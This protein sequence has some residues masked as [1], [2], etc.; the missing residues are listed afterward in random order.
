MGVIT[1]S[2]LERRAYVYVRQSSLAQVRDH[3]ESTRRQYRLQNRACT[4][5]WPEGCVAVIDEDQ[6]QSGA[7]AGNRQGFQRLV[8]EVALGEVGAILGV[9]IS[10]L[11]RS[12]AD[13]YRLMEVAALTGALIIDEEGVYDPNKYNDRLLLGLKATLSEAEL[14]FLKQRMVGGR[15]QKAHRGEYRIRLPAGYIWEDGIRVD[16]DER[17]RE[18]I[19][20]FFTCFERF[21]KAMAVA[22]YFE[23]HRQLFPR[24]DGWGTMQSAVNWGPLS[25]SR[26]VETLRNPIYAGVYAYDRKNPEAVKGEDPFSGGRIWISDSHRGYISEGQ[27]EKNIIRLSEN[28]SFLRGMRGKGS[29]REG[30]SLVQGIVL[31]GVCGKPMLVCYDGEGNGSYYCRTSGTN[32]ACQWIRCASI[33]KT[34]EEVVLDTI[35]HEHLDVALKVFE[36]ISERARELGNQWEKRIEAARYEAD[37]AA[38]RYYQ[39]DPEN[40]LVAR[41][42]E[43]DWNE[44]LAQ[45][46][47]MVEEYQKLRQELPFT[48]TDEQRKRILDLAE[49]IPRLWRE[50]TTRESQRKQL[51]RL[52]IEDVTLLAVDDPWGVEVIVRWKTGVASRHMARRARQAMTPPEVV[53]RMRDLAAGRT[54]RQVAE[55]LD[56]EGYH[57]AS[58]LKF[59]EKMVAALRLRQGLRKPR[60]TSAEL[61]AR[62]EALI[63][64]GTDREI[65]DL[66]NEEGYLSATGKQLTANRVAAI[67]EG[68]G[69]RKP[70]WSNGE[71]VARVRELVP[72][73]TD[74][75][76]AEVLNQENYRSGMGRQFTKRVVAGIRSRHG[77]RRTPRENDE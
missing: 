30:K 69:L 12:C 65:A 15:R 53:T 2:H 59:T 3:Q 75:E 27:Y 13:W 11:A 76:I 33:D 56:Q 34:V 14:H 70:W 32:R 73:Q 1:A 54:D 5:G 43:S 31:C 37:K 10:R 8:S 36:R 57:S 44:K 74:E 42:L 26:A 46:E 6:G 40:R 61:V 17:V 52:L 19:S 21:G 55:L 72:D 63:D 62:I 38:R 41:T 23:D 24:R 66:L 16:P 67:R 49:D 64:K 58:G 28:R 29:P 45:V 25:I 22:R 77:L 20:L 35:T 50:P 48:L 51:V 9:E 7:S 47:S 68:Y 4:L 71:I 39:V 18:T 60:G